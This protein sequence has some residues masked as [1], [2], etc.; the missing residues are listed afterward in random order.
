MSAPV[1]VIGQFAGDPE[2][3]LSSAANPFDLDDATDGA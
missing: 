2:R 3:V 1:P